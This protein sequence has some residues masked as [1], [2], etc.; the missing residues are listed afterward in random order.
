MSSTCKRAALGVPI[1]NDP[2][3]RWEYGTNIDFVGRAVETASGQRLGA[4]LRDNIFAPLE[5]NDTA[6]KISDPMRTRL[7]GMHV[8]GLDGSL[9]PFPFELEQE[10]EFHMGGGGLQDRTRLPRIRP[11]D[12]EQRPQQRPSD[13]QTRNGCTDEPE[14]HRRP[15]HDQ[16]DDSCSAL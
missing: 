6:F 13:A 7:V 16:D 10:P 9:L 12:S 4:Y 14:P 11:D 5:M 3:T 1:V 2:G 15:Q 8:R